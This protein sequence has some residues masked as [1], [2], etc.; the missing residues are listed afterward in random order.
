MADIVHILISIDAFLLRVWHRSLEILIAPKTNTEMLWLLLPLIATLL[1]MEFYFGRHTKE[2]LGW[3]SAYGNALVLLFIAVFL[4]KYINENDLWL[5]AGKMAIMVFLI[6]VGIA[7]TVIDFLHLLPKELA[8]KMSSK[9]P[10]NFIAYATIIL[11]YTDI[12]LD[13]ITLVS[14]IVILIML[15]LIIW[16]IRVS[17]PKIKHTLYPDSVPEPAPEPPEYKETT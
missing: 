2:E 9:L 10:V 13:Y 17:A 4:F 16:F 5:D 3:N 7:L 15:A 12:P 1:L 8:F 14:F 6:T 11:I